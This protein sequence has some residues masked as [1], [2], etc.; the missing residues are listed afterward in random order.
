[1]STPPSSRRRLERPSVVTEWSIRDFKAVEHACLPMTPLTLLLGPNSAGKSSLLQTLLILGQSTEDDIVLNGPLARLGNAEDVIRAGSESTTFG[2]VTR[3]RTPARETP[4]NVLVEITMVNKLGSLVPSE[5]IAID[6]ETD[7]VLLQASSER[8]TKAA[9]DAVARESRR[10]ETLLRIGRIDDKPAPPNTYIALAGMIPI[11][12]C[13]RRTRNNVLSELRRTI[14]VERKDVQSS[15][16]AF[17]TY[18]Q[19]IE[20]LNTRERTK[21]AQT[22]TSGKFGA[23]LEALRRMGNTQIREILKSYVESEFPEEEWIKVPFFGF[24]PNSPG[25][26]T[27]RQ[28]FPPPGQNH[29]SAIATASFAADS[30]RQI[31][32]SLRY[33][34][35]LREEPQVVYP[36]GAAYRTLPTGSKGEYTADFLAR[37]KDT[38]FKYWDW[39]GEEHRQKLSNALTRWVSYLGLGES[40]TVEDQ[41]KLGRGLRIRL[42]GAERDLTMIGVGA[43]QLIPVIVTVLGANQGAIVLLEQPELHLHPSVQSRLADFFLQARR[44]IRLI[45]ETHSEY[46]IT[47]LRRRV[48]ESPELG[49]N[50]SIMFAEQSDGGVT[51]VRRLQL[52]HLGDF[53]AWP[54]GFFDTQDTESAELARAVRRAISSGAEV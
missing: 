24:L 7:T 3:E 50:L 46:L 17:E 16:Q 5:F 52:D 29:D 19:L 22:D 10:H 25:G 1:M 26:R 13:F 37:N 27:S 51:D 32:R 4:V 35:P 41:G 6:Q 45:I 20:W 48:V 30:M 28:S 47:R 33:L 11:A 14:S 15:D 31:Q 2:F 49:K 8:V 54:K 12:V 38:R 9:R 18:F 34:G 39:N 53:S 43:S 44:D 40:V 21:S 23:T 36:T 42:N